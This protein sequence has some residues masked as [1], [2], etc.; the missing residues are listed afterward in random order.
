MRKVATTLI[1]ALTLTVGELH[2]YWQGGTTK[3]NWIISE[4]RPMLIEW[5]VK[6][7]AGQLQFIMYF[8]AWVLY[9]PNRLNK[10]TVWAFFWLAIFD[11]IMYFY[12]YKLH[13]FGK[14]YYWFAAFWAL[15]YYGKK[16][17]NWLW[18]KLNHP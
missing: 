14:I 4:Y 10:T 13:D 1:L 18:N 12:N 17:N 6:F 11:T 16:I 2:T 3:Q 9:R 7:A 8:L 15:S 5:N